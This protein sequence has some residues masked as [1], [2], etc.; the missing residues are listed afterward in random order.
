MQEY[1]QH[2]QLKHTPHISWFAALSLW[3]VEARR[4]TSKYYYVHALDYLVPIC[5]YDNLGTTLN[6]VFSAI[7]MSQW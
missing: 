6:T 4:L 7:F 5:W 3:E 2:M 1:L